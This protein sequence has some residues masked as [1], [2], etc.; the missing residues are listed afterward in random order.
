M[1]EILNLTKK[2]RKKT[3]VDSLSFTFEQGIYG[4]LGPNG[5]GK[6]TLFKCICGLLRPNSGDVRIS[7]EGIGYL[8]QQFGAFGELKVKEMME[9][10][11][12]L[13]GLE[14][15]EISDAIS[16]SLEQVNLTPQT[17]MYVSQLSGGMTRRLG[18]AQALLGNPETIL[19][20]EPTV[21]LDPE[22]RI[23]TIDVISKIKSQKTI[24]VSTHIV[25]DVES[26]C[27]EA[28]VMQEGKIIHTS[29]SGELAD[30]AKGKAF[31]VEERY[32]D[33]VLK[34][35]YIKNTR[36]ENGK[37]YLYVLSSAPQPGE[38]IQPTFEDGYLC[39][40]KGL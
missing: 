14:K 39:V 32:R 38:E 34:T 6:T 9:Y 19:L 23:R 29:K 13:K 20:D 40:I 5:A 30:Y 25:E 10:F 15:A 28:V 33:E 1:I 36:V 12:V 2:Y 16:L 4:V 7:G 27:E 18:I 26:L 8:P 24:L 17:N 21:G 37:T 3:A 11:A 31:L 22:E 35:G